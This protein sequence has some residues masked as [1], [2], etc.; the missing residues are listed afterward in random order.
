M[1]QEIFPGKV[2]DERIHLWIDELVQTVQVVVAVDDVFFG[3]DRNELVQLLL[4]VACEQVV[5]QAVAIVT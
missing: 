3:E 4:T 1:L 5:D 2:C